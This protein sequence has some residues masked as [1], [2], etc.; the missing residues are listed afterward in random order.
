MALEMFFSKDGTHGKSQDGHKPGQPLHSSYP[1]GS[2]FIFVTCCPQALPDPLRP[3]PPRTIWLCLDA[4]YG[5]SEQSRKATLG[6]G[7]AGLL[8]GHLHYPSLQSP[9]LRPTGALVITCLFFD[10][11]CRFKCSE[12]TLFSD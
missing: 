6:A 5:A 12:L 1:R 4:F 10:Q 7:A 8:P 11:S 9:H 3:P 2:F